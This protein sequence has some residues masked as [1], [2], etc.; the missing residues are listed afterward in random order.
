MI[1]DDAHTKARIVRITAE[2]IDAAL[3]AG[4]IAVVAGFRG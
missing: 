1:T 2:R 4:K 3:A